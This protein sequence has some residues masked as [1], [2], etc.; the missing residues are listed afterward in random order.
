M[1][2]FGQFVSGLAKFGLYLMMSNKSLL[3]TCPVCGQ[4]LSVKMATKT[5]LMDI[6]KIRKT[7]ILG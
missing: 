1:A 3:A 7:A 6:Q 4:V 5:Y 2:T